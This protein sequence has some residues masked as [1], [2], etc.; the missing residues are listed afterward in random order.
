M[1]EILSVAGITSIL[2]VIITLLF[3]YFPVLRVKWGG[4]ATNVKMLIVLALYLVI[5]A[6]VGF[7]GC[8]A[9]FVKLI[10]NLLCSDPVT[11]FQYAFAVTA[12]IGS[13]QGV[14]SLLPELKD[15]TIAK[16]AR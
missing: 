15:V 16:A 14:F 12:A 3:Q 6:V 11:F 13:G 1:N 7:G 10:P 2:V 8:I 4:V 5:G 9:L